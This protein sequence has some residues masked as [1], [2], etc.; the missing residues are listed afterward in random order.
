MSS[1]RVYI[2]PDDSVGSRF[3]SNGQLDIA[4]L[5][6]LPALLVTETGGDGPQFA[7]VTHIT[8]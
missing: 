3:Y 7:K 4:K 8:R 1:G 5:N 2:R 6:E